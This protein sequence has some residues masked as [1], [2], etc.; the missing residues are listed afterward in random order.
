M[1]MKAGKLLKPL[2]AGKL[3]T[4]TMRERLDAQARAQA[5]L[6]AQQA[7]QAQASMPGSNQPAPAAA[8][9]STAD[10]EVLADL[11]DQRKAILQAILGGN[12]A[13]AAR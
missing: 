11:F 8:A 5:A 10:S 7:Q 2:R 4:R 6:Q 3:Q 13:G 1:V 12:D 9:P